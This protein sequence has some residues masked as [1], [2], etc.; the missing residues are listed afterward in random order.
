MLLLYLIK[1]R[2][3]EVELHAFLTLVLEGV[4]F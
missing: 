2:A 1:N 3:M 4:E